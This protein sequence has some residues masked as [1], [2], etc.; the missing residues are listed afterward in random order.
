MSFKN[1]ILQPPLEL[2]KE[3]EEL[4]NLF[5]EIKEGKKFGVKL[6][7]K[8]TNEYWISSTNNI[9]QREAT[10]KKILTKRDEW[11]GPWRDIFSNIPDVKI[12]DDIEFQHIQDFNLMDSKELFYQNFS[13]TIDLRK[14]QVSFMSLLRTY[15]KNIK[16][17]QAQLSE[18]RVLVDGFFKPQK[19]E[20]SLKLIILVEKIDQLIST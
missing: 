5:F 1:F 13:T 2:V 6:T 3:I 8:N 7:N 16:I 11:N 17:V 19:D 9:Q 10:L 18:L 15:L 12:L 14:I 20:K 4:K